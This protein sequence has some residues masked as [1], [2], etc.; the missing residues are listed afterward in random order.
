M[1]DE[2]PLGISVLTGGRTTIPEEVMEFLDLRYS[3][4]G[5]QKLL[6][7]QEGTDVIVKKGTLQSSFRKTILT[8]GGKAAVPKH[9]REALE[10]S[11]TSDGE[12]RILWN[13]RGDDVV[14][15]KEKS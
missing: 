6:W 8:R 1:A 13:R 7:L 14:V 12:E 15:I 2:L 3:P 4:K 5:R 10:L 11:Y 9:I